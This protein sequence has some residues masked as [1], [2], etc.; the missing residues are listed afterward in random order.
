MCRAQPRNLIRTDPMECF[1][2]TPVAAVVPALFRFKGHPMAKA[3]LET[4]VL[5]TELRAHGQSLANYLGAT[6]VAVACGVSVGIM[7]SIPQLLDAVAGWLDTSYLRG[8]AQDR[9]RVG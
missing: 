3:A 4:A 6:R 2:T 7:D 1:A 8:Q 5:D 9:A